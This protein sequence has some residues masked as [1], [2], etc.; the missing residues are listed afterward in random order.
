MLLG[1]LKEIQFSQA[2]SMQIKHLI[3]DFKPFNSLTKE[4][5]GYGPTGSFVLA[6]YYQTI[7]GLKEKA[8]G[9]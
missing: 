9:S 8:A 3:K 5:G 2:K 6:N 4:M 1:N 7:K